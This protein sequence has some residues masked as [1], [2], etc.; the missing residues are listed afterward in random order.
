MTTKIKRLNIA[1]ILINAASLITGFYVY[2]ESRN[3]LHEIEYNY[4]VM[5]KGFKAIDAE[6]WRELSIVNEYL[7][8]ASLN[9]KIEDDS[10][11]RLVLKEVRLGQYYSDYKEAIT[12][13]LYDI[14]RDLESRNG[15]E[16]FLLGMILSLGTIN[17]IYIGLRVKWS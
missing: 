14:Q 5:D 4:S 11:S 16:T 2:L 15:I 13:T 12:E 3:T 10:I 8:K 6:H 17:L 9:N 1:I 7:D